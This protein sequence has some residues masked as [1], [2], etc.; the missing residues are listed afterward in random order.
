MLDD[1]AAIYNLVQTFGGRGTLYTL[2]ETVTSKTGV[3]VAVTV[4]YRL[5]HLVRMPDKRLY[6]ATPVP[7]M[8]QKP[9]SYSKTLVRF[10]ISKDELPEGFEPQQ[11]NYIVYKG[12]GYQVESTE[13]SDYRGAFFCDC[14]KISGDV[15]RQIFDVRMKDIIEFT[16][17]LETS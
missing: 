1:R 9:F 5:K 16:E 10:L 2:T 15:P 6:V 12:K 3:I 17:T 13:Y 11:T 8:G 4:P 14:S 7:Q